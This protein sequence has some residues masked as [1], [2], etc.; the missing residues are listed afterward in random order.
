[1]E[2]VFQTV[3]VFQFEQAKLI[4]DSAEIPFLERN[5]IVSMY[6]NFGTY[7][8][9]VSSQ[10]HLGSKELIENAFK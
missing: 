5:T 6:N 9:Y 7:E 4:L 1:M 8:L 3:D 10:H 2:L